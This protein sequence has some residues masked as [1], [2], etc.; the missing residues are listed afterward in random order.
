MPRKA[1]PSLGAKNDIITNKNRI[2]LALSTCNG[3][4]DPWLAD[5]LKPIGYVTFIGDSLHPKFSLN[6]KFE[7]G[8]EYAIYE[9]QKVIFVI[10]KVG[11]GHRF[12]P[13]A[14]KINS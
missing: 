9:F 1:N 3:I 11:T 6:D 12:N 4:P 14:W 7:K 8:K 13:E 10:C 5:K 2:R